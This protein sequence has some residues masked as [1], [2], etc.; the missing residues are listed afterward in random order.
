[1]AHPNPSTF[2]I[3]LWFKFKVNEESLLC[4]EMA[5]N[6]STFSILL[7]EKFKFN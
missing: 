7:F 4:F 3:L 5:P 1:M 6:T 2:S